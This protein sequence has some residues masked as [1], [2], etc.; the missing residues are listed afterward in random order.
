[1]IDVIITILSWT[2]GVIAA[3]FLLTVLVG[4]PYVPTHARQFRRL[5]KDLELSSD[6]VLVD[7][8]SG[9]GKILKL[10][11]PK[12]KRAI[13]YEINPFLVLL[14]RWFLRKNDNVTIKLAD[15]RRIS[16]PSDTTVV[17]IFS[18]GIFKAEVIQLL[19]KHVAKTAQ[20]V[21]LISYGFEFEAQKMIF[22]KHGFIIYE[23]Y[24]KK[25]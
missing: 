20:T 12:L 23:I 13:G 5:L 21:C 22:K 9:D 17:Y 18:A 4:A 7:L 15:F 11:S 24:P 14:S 6:D 16:L 25:H 10:A 8:G 1:M 19:E 3:M 2:G